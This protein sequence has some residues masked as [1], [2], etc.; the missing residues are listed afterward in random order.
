MLDTGIAT[1]MLKVFSIC[2]FQ[3]VHGQLHVN[4]GNRFSIGSH[5]GN[6]TTLFI[7]GKESFSATKGPF[8]VSG[9]L[10]HGQGVKFKVSAI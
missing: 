1:V 4:R 9:V 6:P 8:T 7:A 10:S 2:Q 5:V 3:S